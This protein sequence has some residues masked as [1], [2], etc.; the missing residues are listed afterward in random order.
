MEEC[1]DKSLTIIKASV[2]SAGFIIGLLLV[3]GAVITCT[4]LLKK[5]NQHRQSIFTPKDDNCKYKVHLLFK[6]QIKCCLLSSRCMS[7]LGMVQ[8]IFLAVRTT[9]QRAVCSSC[10]ENYVVAF[11]S[12]LKSL[13]YLRLVYPLNC[14]LKNPRSKIITKILTLICC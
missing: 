4:V 5:R 13:I 1:T 3:V 10:R 14:I 8:S 6:K 12:G 9:W 11:S 2:A 7:L